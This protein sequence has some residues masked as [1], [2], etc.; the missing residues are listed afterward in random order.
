MSKFTID[1]NSQF[2]SNIQINWVPNPKEKIKEIIYNWAKQKEWD[3]KRQRDAKLL[4]GYV[5]H[6]LYEGEHSWAFTDI[7][8]SDWLNGPK[9]KD[10]YIQ[11]SPIVDFAD[12]RRKIFDFQDSI[13]EREL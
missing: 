10:G 7:S 3:E 4:I 8:M 11:T 9:G 13:N 12:S 2:I 5:E 1:F 6:N